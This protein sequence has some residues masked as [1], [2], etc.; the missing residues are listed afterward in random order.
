MPEA[1]TNP[2]AVKFANEQV[3]RIA[4]TYGRTLFDTDKVLALWRA[5]GLAELIPNDDSLIADGAG[6][7]GRRAITGADLHGMIGLL[8]TVEGLGIANGGA[9]KALILRIAVNPAG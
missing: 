3:R 9:S 6:S 4:D 5:H 8:Q 7:D 2:L 1:V